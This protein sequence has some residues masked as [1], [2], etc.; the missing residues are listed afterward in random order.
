[1]KTTNEILGFRI[2]QALEH[3]PLPVEELGASLSDLSFT[4]NELDQVLFQLVNQ[5]YWIQHHGVV[6]GGCKTC[7]CSVSYVWRLSR[8][9][10]EE[11]NNQRNQEHAL[12]P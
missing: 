1:M 5:K 2:L 7:A 3:K 11:L 8:A 4:Q 9:G 12:Q 6:G 10:R